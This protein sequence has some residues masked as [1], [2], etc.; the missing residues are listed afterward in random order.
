MKAQD[1]RRKAVVSFYADVEPSLPY[2]SVN[3][4]ENPMSSNATTALP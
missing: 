3:R 2:L 1:H 4:K